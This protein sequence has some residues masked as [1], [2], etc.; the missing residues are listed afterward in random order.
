M[1]QNNYSPRVNSFLLNHWKRLFATVAEIA[2]LEPK[3]YAECGFFHD[4]RYTLQSRDG[5][6]LSTLQASVYEAP[7]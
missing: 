3:M 7:T 4:T 2:S 6:F 5:V 1:T